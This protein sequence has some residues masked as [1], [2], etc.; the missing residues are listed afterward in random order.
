MIQKKWQ[1]LQQ[2]KMDK[3]VGDEKIIL[4]LLKNR[5]IGSR[6]KDEFLNPISPF[7]LEPKS[8]GIRKSSLEKAVNIIKKI[9]KKKKIIVY[10][11]YDVDGFSASA[12]IWETLWKKGFNVLPFI[13]NRERD[14]YGLKEEVVKR[15]KQENPDLGLII[16]VD[17]GIVAF[18]AINLARSL[19]IKTIITDHH[20]VSEKEPL[21][22]AIVHSTKIAGSGVAWFLARQFGYRSLDLVTLGTIAD[23]LPL[24]EVNRSFVKHGLKRLAQTERI[25]LQL[26]K[27]E[28]GISEGE[29]LPWQISFVLAPRLNAVGRLADATDSLRLLCTNS[30]S[31]ARMLVGKMEKTNRRRQKLTIDGAAHAKEKIGSKPGKIVFAI[32]KSYHQGV[33][34]LVAFK[35]V[36]EFCRPSIVIWKGKTISKGSARSVGSCNI[37]ELIKKGEKF[38]I[39]VGGHPMAAGFTIETKKINDFVE[40][41]SKSAEREIKMR[42]L[43]SQLKI[44]F[45]MDFS[46]INKNFYSLLQ[47]LAPFGIGN[48]EPTFLIKNARVVGLKVMGGSQQHLKLQL[49]DP[50]TPEIERIIAEAVGFGWGEWQDRLFPG[51]LVDLVFN[52][53]LNKW[54]GRETLQ[55]KIKDLR[56]T[57]EVIK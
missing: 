15:L 40:K 55:L 47:K 31:K 37:I 43:I 57:G 1:L 8:V 49:D 11:D 6:K 9:G 42:D 23:M 34:G 46:L 38:L 5:N 25:G 3:G 35:L 28:T 41:V 44:D 26:L 24:T 20:L 14:G 7:K 39:D 22:D 21:A 17:N 53:N 33:I 54:N 18:D 27:K 56:K 51:D 29:L 45:E 2:G 13:P 52:L 12:I 50:Q 4:K 10:G 16:T 48:P 19:G 36:E 30:V 32:D